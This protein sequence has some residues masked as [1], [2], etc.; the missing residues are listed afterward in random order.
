MSCVTAASRM[1][2]A[3]SRDRAVPGHSVWRQLDKNHNPSYAAFAVAIAAII[4]TLPALITVSGHEGMPIAFFAVTSVTVIGLY[5]AFMIPIWLRFKA[6]D[7]F[8]AGPW[9][10]GNKYRWMCPVAVA[11]IIIICIYFILPTVPSGVPFNKHFQFG[12]VQYA[13]VA[14][15]IVVGG[16]MLWWI[17]LGEEVVHRPGAHDRRRRPD[18]HAITEPV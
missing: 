17:A 2:F 14:I 12:N 7:S 11:E 16:A 13:P 10:L 15:V 5:L 1:L 9:S 6:G 8:Q 4:L 18:A 3:F